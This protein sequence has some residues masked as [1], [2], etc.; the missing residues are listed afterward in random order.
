ML[1]LCDYNDIIENSV[2]WLK[3]CILPRVILLKITTIHAK[4]DKVVG[5]IPDVQM[6]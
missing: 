4:K 6:E 2:F 5:T 3:L 1:M